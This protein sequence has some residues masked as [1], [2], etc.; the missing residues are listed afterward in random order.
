MSLSN[1]YPISDRK[2]EYTMCFN[3]RLGSCMIFATETRGPPG[4]GGGV[5]INCW[6]L[7]ASIECCLTPFL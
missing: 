7:I 6:L 5:T 4:G 1:L 3:L 2:I